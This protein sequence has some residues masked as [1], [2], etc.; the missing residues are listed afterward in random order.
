MIKHFDVLPHA[1]LYT[2]LKLHKIMEF[3]VYC[4]TVGGIY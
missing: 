1:I 2:P 3:N 4:S